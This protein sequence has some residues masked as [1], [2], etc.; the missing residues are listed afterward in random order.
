MSSIPVVVVAGLHAEV[1]AEA[2]RRLLAATP[3]SLAVHHDLRGIG[4]GQV[5]R[6]VLD[7]WGVR[8]RADVRLA[9]GCVSCTIREDVLPAI[10]RLA[11]EA[12][13]LVIETWGS[14]EPRAVA[15]QIAKV[16]GVHL[17]GVLTAAD[18]AGVLNDLGGGERL[19]DRALTA[20]EEDERYVAEVLVR[21]IEYAST[22]ILGAG[23]PEDVLLAQTVLEHLGAGTPVTPLD[24]LTA[25]HGA[26]DAATLAARVDPES[27]RLPVDQ[28]SDGVATMIWRRPRPLH[29]VRLYEAIDDLATC[30]VRS[31][32]RLWLANRPDVL[33]GW[34][35]VSGLLAIEDRGRWLAARSSRAWSKATPARRAAAALDWQP[36]TGDRTQLLAFTGPE[37]DRP[38]MT[39]LL[40]RCLL[41]EAEMRAG[42]DA[43][44]A[45]AD[46]FA[47]VLD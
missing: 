43:W 13:L 7:A 6:V 2:V 20:S 32:G 38:A 22:L 36:K 16:P 18:P 27:L 8:E 47:G 33:L 24:E 10:E 4:H 17:T 30:A 31:R 14:V 3:Y 45:Y 42:S 12:R 28:D 37:L 39:H 40:D 29:P 15:E 11:S 34:D 46:P 44:A 41:T 1:R 25:P 9:H 23:E 5:E 21:Q 35:C 19:R 26:L